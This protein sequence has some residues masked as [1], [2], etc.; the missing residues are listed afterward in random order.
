MKEL[1]LLYL[2]VTASL[3]GF[4]QQADSSLAVF[5]VVQQGENVFLRWTIEAGNT[6]QGTRIERSGDGQSFEEIGEIPG[7]CGSPDQPI[8]YEYTDKEPLRNSTNYYRL[9]MGFLGYTS[10]VAVDFII[11]NDE[12]Y[13]LQPNPVT[14]T[15]K[16]LF[17]N[18]DGADARLYIYDSTGRQV[19]E[20]ITN[21]SHIYIDGNFFV[22]GF[23][24][25][26]IIIGGSLKSVGKFIV[27]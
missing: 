6:C 14:S 12:G 21:E 26:R 27:I 1:I 10:V 16:L 8:S 4:T 11:L 9:E 7:V 22:S 23:Y 5:L 19:M 24:A 20:Y 2:L 25:F 3:V 13:S 18:P 15:S 17:D